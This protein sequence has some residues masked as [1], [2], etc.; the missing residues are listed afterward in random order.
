[1]EKLTRIDLSCNSFSVFPLEAMLSAK[2]VD[3]D[4]SA[5]QVSAHCIRTCRWCFDTVQSGIG[6][7]ALTASD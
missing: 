5:N 7:G 4:L 2:L 3:I 1:M 6:T